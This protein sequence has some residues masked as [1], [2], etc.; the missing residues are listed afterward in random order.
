M[1]KDELLASL[2][3]LQRD[4]SPGPDGW[5][6]K[7]FMD[8]FNL[9]GEYLLKVVEEFFLTVV[10]TGSLNSTFLTLIPEN[11]QSAS[12]TDYRPISFCNLT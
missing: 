2:K 8:L 5:T 10:I 4:K 1:S 9:I 7:F 11:D 6:K 12:F 3:Y